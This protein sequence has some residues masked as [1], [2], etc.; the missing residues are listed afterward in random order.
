MLHPY[1]I[2][3]YIY[4]WRNLTLEF[5]VFIHVQTRWFEALNFRFGLTAFFEWLLR[6]LLGTPWS[7]KFLQ[8]DRKISCRKNETCYFEQFVLL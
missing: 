4:V 7:C 3:I 8:L 5:A 2:Y 1:E 6:L